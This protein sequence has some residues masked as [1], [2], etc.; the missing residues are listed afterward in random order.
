MITLDNRLIDDN[1]NVVYFTKALIEML[2]NGLQPS[3]MLIFPKD[4]IDV[5][6]F[7]KYAYENYDD[8]KYSL[9]NSIESLENR[10]DKWVYPKEYD[11][12]LLDDYFHKLCKN[13]I[14]RNRVDEELSLYHSKGFDKFLRC[15]IWLSDEIKKNDWVVGCGRGSSVSSF[16]LYLIKL[17]LVDSI[18]YN[19]DIHEFLK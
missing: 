18:K 7:N 4:D 11:S 6:A 3:E 9:P 12:I 19:L 8:V 16:C 5:V 10:R 17:H 15:C 14:E 13:D 2:Y 1:G